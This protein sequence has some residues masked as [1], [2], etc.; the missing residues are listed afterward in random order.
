MKVPAGKFG[1]LE[2]IAFVSGFSLMAFELIGARMLA[3]TIGS[4]TYVWTSVIGVIIAALSVG[5]FVGGKVADI[6][7]RAGDVALLC[8]AGAFAIGSMLLLFDG[9]MEWVVQLSPDLRLRGVFASLL[10]FAP[11]SLV[12]GMLSPYLVKLKVTSLL[13]SGQSVAALSASNSIGGIVGTFITG[14]VVFSYMGSREAL[15]VLVLLMLGASWLVRPK[16][17]WRLRALFSLVA[18]FIV[19]VPLGYKTDSIRI[20]TPSSHYEIRTGYRHENKAQPIR[21]LTTGPGGAQ[22]GIYTNQPNELPFWYTRQIVKTV[23]QAPDKQNILVLGGGAFTIPEYLARHYP[24]S[25]IDVVEID[26][27]LK[28]IAKKYFDYQPLENIQAIDGDARTYINTVAK[29]YNV[30]IVD[31]YSDVSVPFSLL[32]KEYASKLGSVITN[33]GLVIINAIAAETGPCA[34]LLQGIDA[35]YRAVGPYATITRENSAQKGEQGN[36]VLTYSKKNQFL[37]GSL[38]LNSLGGTSYSDDF[39]PAERLQQV[40]QESV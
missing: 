3:P 11:A 38:L 37:S 40:C 20:D 9:I 2:L 39:M 35:T 36:L 25:S 8:L 21:Y 24:K 16:E 6:R 30:V 17:G 1:K 26:P 28:E 7:G 10:L 15:V 31:V 23:A 13:I 5:Y 4:S 22:S 14:F 34:E 33:N 29:H 18:F 19:V 32:T 27:S 12:L